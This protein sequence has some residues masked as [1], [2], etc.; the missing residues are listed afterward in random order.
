MTQK[1]LYREW[2]DVELGESP[3]NVVAKTWGGGGAAPRDVAIA[4]VPVCNNL[5]NGS[6]SDSRI[7][8]T[9]LCRQV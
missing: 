4:G 9:I 1:P 8:T 3:D 7:V 2:L 6:A 5:I